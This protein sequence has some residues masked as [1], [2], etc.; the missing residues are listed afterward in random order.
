VPSADAKSSPRPQLTSIVVV[1]GI[2][3]ILGGILQTAGQNKET[4]LA[5]RFFAGVGIGNLALLAP[6]YQSE[7]GG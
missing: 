7:I 6:L 4:I 5:G 2:I 3:F 1:G